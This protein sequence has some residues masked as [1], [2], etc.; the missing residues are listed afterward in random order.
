MACQ[1]NNTQLRPAFPASL[2]WHFTA[3]Q[4]N[5][6]QLLTIMLPSCAGH[7]IAMFVILVHGLSGCPTV[8]AQLRR[9][10][11]YRHPVERQMQASGGEKENQRACRYSGNCLGLYS[12]DAPRRQEARGKHQAQFLANVL[13]WLTPPP[14]NMEAICYS[15]T[16]VNVYHTT[17]CHIREARTVH[18]DRCESLR[19]TSES[20]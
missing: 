7:T 19:P 2:S 3:Q 15:K 5:P 9:I 14:V 16:S 11:G 6:I 20:V 18:A 13:A 8:H 17:R 10:C 4:Q 12:G 1:N